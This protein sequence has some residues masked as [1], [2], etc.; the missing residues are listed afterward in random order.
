MKK[1]FQ[2]I[3]VLLI[4]TLF[5]SCIGGKSETDLKLIPV[6]SGKYWG[7]IDHE[8]KYVI[9]PQFKGALPF[10]DGLALVQAPDGKFG[11]I[12]EDGKYIINPNYKYATDFVDGLALAVK[13]D[14]KIEIINI[15]GE[16]KATL[17][18]SISEANKFS[19]GLSKVLIGTKY[20]YINQDGKIVIPANFANAEN[21]SEGFAAVGNGAGI[22][23][24]NWGNLSV[25]HKELERYGFINKKGEL[26]INYQFESASNFSENLAI[27]SNGSKY[28]Y[29]GTDGK[30]KINP[31]FEM[32]SMFIDDF[33][34]FRQGELWGY[35]NKKGEIVINPQFKSVDLFY[36]NYLAPAITA[37]GK[38][39]YIDVDGKYV[40]NP[41]FDQAT[42]FYGDIA[43]IYSNKKFGIIDQ[44]G[45]II[46]EPQF[47]YVLTSSVPKTSK[48]DCEY[49]DA[50][51]ITNHLAKLITQTTVAE[52]NFETP[53]ATVV[54]NYKLAEE[55]YSKYKNELN[56]FDLTLTEDVAIS[57]SAF[58]VFELEVNNYDGNPVIDKFRY[59]VDLKPHFMF[60]SAT[61]F[62]ALETAFSGY[63][64]DLENSRSDNVILKGNTQEINIW[65]SGSNTI[66]IRIS[67][68]NG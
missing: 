47:D 10:S 5:S 9:N 27:F 38:C 52:M 29:I 40:I 37:D 13:E 24:D 22:I 12:A 36:G 19:E 23:R 64:K 39:G 58:L 8:G 16:T 50:N 48:V 43:F 31:Q 7:Y 26:V 15:K 49:F 2:S 51:A 33:A 3:I 17:D 32:A 41:Q 56:R 34:A 21:F 30:I 14:S 68:I 18:E 42:R 61:L 65:S 46:V 66:Y 59:R 53:M 55:K 44:K 20:G 54:S 63:T 4:V 6:L 25:T 35:I 62:S 57:N 45:K 1:N 67:K 28:G 60:K 11:Y